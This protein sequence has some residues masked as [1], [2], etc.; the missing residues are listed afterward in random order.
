MITLI[1]VKSS[2]NCWSYL[3]EHRYPSNILQHTEKWLTWLVMFISH[4]DSIPGRTTSPGLCTACKAPDKPGIALLWLLE[5]PCSV[6][7]IHRPLMVLEA[8]VWNAGVLG[9]YS[10][11][12]QGALPWPLAAC[13]AFGPSLAIFDLGLQ[14]QNLC[15]S[16]HTMQICPPCHVDVFTWQSPYLSLSSLIL[17]TFVTLQ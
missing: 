17:R 15:L 5:G 2:R 12:C 13:H 9:S 6:A 8:T 3:E 1:T 11:A 10:H 14:C 7:L 4:W 16:C